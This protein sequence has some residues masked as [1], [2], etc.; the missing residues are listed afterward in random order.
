MTQSIC[1]NCGAE[2]SGPFTRCST[3]NAIPSDDE[4]LARSLA[5]SEHL[6]SKGQLAV[7]AEDIRAHRKL[8]FAPGIIEQ[9]RE[10]LKDK[11]LLAMLGMSAGK[12]RQGTGPPPRTARPVPVDRPPR[13]KI[14]VRSDATALTALDRTP[15]GILGATTR[16]DRRRIVELAEE[17]SLTADAED[18]TKV[19]SDLT[20]PRK[21]LAAEL[22][23]LP[24]LSP[25][26][27]SA[28]R[29]LLKQDIDFF[30]ASA[31]K[32]SPLV[33]A[34]LIAAAME[35]FDP[36]TSPADWASWISKLACQVDQIDPEEVLRVINE[37]R[38]VA[39]FTEIPGVKVVEDEL[40]ERRRSLRAVIQE[41]IER[42]PAARMIQAVTE[43]V[44]STTDSGSGQAPLLID[45]L[46]DSF[47]VGARPFLD[48]EAENVLT[49]VKRA[50]H[51]A[52]S[53]RRS[54]GPALDEL[55]SVV[56]NWDRVAHPIQVSMKARGIEHEQSKR[57]AYEIRSLGV[58]LFNKHGM[59]EE[60][61]RVTRILQAVFGELP[62]VANRLEEDAEAIEGIF[63]SREE[64]TR[65]TEEWAQEITFE[66]QIGLLFK[67]TLRISPRGIEWKNSRYPLDAIT[68]VGWGATRNSVN[69]IP[70]GTDYF[71]LFGDRRDVTTVHLKREHVFHGFVERLWKA[72]CVR[73]LTELLAGLREGKRYQFGDAVLDDHG[74]ELTKHRF[75]RA[76][77]KVRAN[78]AQLQM[79]NSNGSLCVGV[80]DDD[81][82]HVALPY[83]EA[84]N[85]HVLELAIRM[86]FKNG[87]ARLSSV[88]EGH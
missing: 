77:E 25:K 14:R 86:K 82:A 88:L 33:Q 63:K 65:R 85:A 4:Q 29:I 19:R 59:L 61:R 1:F 55:E 32:E 2:K 7:F 68:R 52:A 50:S 60:A 83:Q 67:D 3:C 71:I 78:W 56:R 20:N 64:S 84:N 8:A 9:A 24:G 62:E 47:E 23:W 36:E 31:A 51:S 87:S 74:M 57:L 37:D 44:E 34:N 26:R 13:G 41:A 58:D 28:Y 80:K 66:A 21:R 10:A 6:H 38:T 79:W 42:M 39:A 27:I 46:I 43:V 54:V 49:L 40:A 15:F 69:G 48:G 12:T 18:C 75:F 16:D 73:L 72:V 76:N 11:Q 70:S 81:K 22:A 5:L 45:D 17:R 53:G 30:L 35:R